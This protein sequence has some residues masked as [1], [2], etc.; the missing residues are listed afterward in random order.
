MFLFSYTFLHTNIFRAQQK[1]MNWPCWS[2]T[3][4]EDCIFKNLWSDVVTVK[5]VKFVVIKHTMAN[6]YASGACSAR[7]FRGGSA[8]SGIVLCRTRVEQEEHSDSY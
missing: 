2:Y 5:G 6:P 7:L 1:Q 3:F 4:G 8:G